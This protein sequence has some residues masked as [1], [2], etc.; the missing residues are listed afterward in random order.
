MDHYALCIMVP[1]L[2]ENI[3]GSGV[4]VGKFI[5]D[6]DGKEYAKSELWLGSFPSIL[7]LT[8]FLVD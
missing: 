4:K 6:G 5:A 3:A 2:S 1:L 8:L 7:F